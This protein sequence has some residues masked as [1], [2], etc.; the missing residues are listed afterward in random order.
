MLPRTL[1]NPKSVPSSAPV[2]ASLPS[3]G[4]TTI[5]A[6][7]PSRS[8]IASAARVATELLSPSG[9]MTSVTS[10][11]RPT[12]T[13]AIDRGNAAD[14]IPAPERLAPAQQSA[15]APANGGDPATTTTPPTLH[16]C[17]PASRRG[18]TDAAQLSVMSSADSV[19]LA[20]L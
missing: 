9:K 12:T 4:P 10:G 14:T 3:P 17:A 1:V 16:L 5:A 6:D 15:A 8:P 2:A 18:R 13:G 11:T 7:R 20:P 19:G